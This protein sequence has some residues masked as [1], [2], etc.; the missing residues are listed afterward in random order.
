MLIQ[1]IFVKLQIIVRSSTIQ[2]LVNHRTVN[3]SEKQNYII[4]SFSSCT[5]VVM[6]PY[7]ILDSSKNILLA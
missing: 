4:F 2:L 6:V 3:L 5:L 7:R 1:Q